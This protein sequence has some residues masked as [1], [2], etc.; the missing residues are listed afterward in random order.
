MFK[1]KKN[2]QNDSICETKSTYIIVESIR[3]SNRNI[4][5]FFIERLNNLNFKRGGWETCQILFSRQMESFP[6]ERTGAKEEQL[7]NNT[8]IKR[9]TVN[10]YNPQR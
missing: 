10:F 8:V 7:S 1:K 4:K 2:K 6:P 5:F 9:I 3:D